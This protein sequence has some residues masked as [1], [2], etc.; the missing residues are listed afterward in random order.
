MIV[1]SINSI[2]AF[3][4]RSLA[5]AAEVMFSKL[6]FEAKMG[7]LT[8][9]ASEYCAKYPEKSSAIRKMIAPLKRINEDVLLDAEKRISAKSNFSKVV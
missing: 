2:N 8:N 6:Y 3:G 9:A 4:A 1:N 5:P 7:N